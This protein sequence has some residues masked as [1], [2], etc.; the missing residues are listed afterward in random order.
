MKK[1]KVEKKSRE[2]ASLNEYIINE[3]VHEQNSNQ[4][5]SKII[6]FGTSGVPGYEK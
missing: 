4:T 3:N 6:I 2:T 1:I 5:G